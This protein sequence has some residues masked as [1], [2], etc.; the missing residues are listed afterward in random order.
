MIFTATKSELELKDNYLRD[1]I[2]TEPSENLGHIQEPATFA[3][4]DE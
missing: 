3:I 2:D 4:M 1:E